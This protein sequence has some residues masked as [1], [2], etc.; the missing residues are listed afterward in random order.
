M[1]LKRIELYQ[2]R[3]ELGTTISLL[4]VRVVNSPKMFTVVKLLGQPIL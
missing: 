1:T 3:L 4:I 2:D